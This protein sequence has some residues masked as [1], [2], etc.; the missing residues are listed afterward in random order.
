MPG[1]GV[2]V[3]QTSEVRAK[4]EQGG[5]TVLFLQSSKMNRSGDHFGDKEKWTGKPHPH[6]PLR[7]LLLRI[8]LEKLRPPVLG[9]RGRPCLLYTSDAADEHRDV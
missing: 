4:G 1:N 8:P 3:Q 2:Y 5:H 7:A 9:Q 6:V